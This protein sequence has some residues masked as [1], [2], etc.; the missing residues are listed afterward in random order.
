MKPLMNMR[1]TTSRSA[2][3]RPVETP[4]KAEITRSHSDNTATVSLTEQH[5]HVVAVG[6]AHR[7]QIRQHIGGRDATLSAFSC[8]DPKSLMNEYSIHSP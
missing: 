6:D 8:W 7:V 3:F 1:T 4:D 5:E 2:S